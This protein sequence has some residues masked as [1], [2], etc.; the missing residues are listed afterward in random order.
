MVGVVNRDVIANGAL[1]ARLMLCWRLR[2][3]DERLCLFA[4]DE[5]AVQSARGVKVAA[6]LDAQGFSHTA[7][8]H[9]VEASD[10]DKTLDLLRRLGVVRRVEED[11]GPGRATRPRSQ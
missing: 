10:P 7:H 11:C 4:I 3:A 9:R 5:A 6:D 2:P 8:S 1:R